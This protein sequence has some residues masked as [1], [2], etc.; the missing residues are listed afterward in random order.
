MDP[1]DIG[2]SSFLASLRA[3]NRREL[4]QLLPIEFRE[5]VDDTIREVVEN[6]SN[7][8]SCCVDLSCMPRQIMFKLLPALL[9]ACRVGVRLFVSYA[10]PKEY[11]QGTL[12]DPAGDVH[13]WTSAGTSVKGNPGLIIIPGFDSE[14]CSLM[15]MYVR[16]RNNR[17]EPDT[18]WLFPVGKDRYSLY[19]RSLEENL[20][21]VGSSACELLP[22][23]EIAMATSQVA[24]LVA[25]HADAP[26]YIAPLG[27]RISCVSVILALRSPKLAGRKVS[28]LL[29]RTARYRSVRSV[30]VTGS[31]VEE[32][33][34]RNGTRDEV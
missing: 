25:G 15:L 32:L 30:G 26:V 2:V 27:P 17:H 12:Q 24:T 8:M 10:Y 28:V 34:V 4:Q 23:D 9:E 22:Q 6:I 14:F 13:E 31:L 18:K 16:M 20:Y 19:E 11:V 29:P 5:D 3:E 33:L 1:G 7:H 21:L